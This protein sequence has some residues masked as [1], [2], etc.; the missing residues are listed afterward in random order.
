M[1]LEC[2]TKLDTWRTLPSEEQSIVFF[3]CLFHD[4]GKPDMTRIDED[5]HVSSR[6]HSRRGAISARKILW[7]NSIP[8]ASREQICGLIRYHRIPFTS[9]GHANAERIAIEVSQVIRPDLLALVA[10]AD[11][12]GRTCKDQQRS[13]DNIELWNELCR[14]LN[15]LSSPYLFSNDHAR[16]LYFRDTRRTHHTPAWDSARGL[17]T[18][19]SGA[20]GAGKDRWI[21]LNMQGV[22]V[23]SLDQIREELGVDPRKPQGRVA[24]EARNRARTYLRTGEPFIWNATNLS[25]DMRAR[26]INLCADYDARIRVTYVESHQ[27]RFWKQNL[28]RERVVPTNVIE[29]LLM[30][31]TIPTLLEAHEIDIAV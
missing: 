8:F 4:I 20:P 18:I 28:K 21:K 25:S 27:D 26:T 17:V 30:R 16:F 2:L 6:G 11:A 19:M 3:A 13:L 15:C 12:L 10:Q 23:I 24:Q 14:D 5:G 31:W 22:P 9:I 1:V 7:E 29:R